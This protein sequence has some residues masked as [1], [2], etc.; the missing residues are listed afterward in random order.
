MNEVLGSIYLVINQINGKIYVG[1][2][3]KSIVRRWAEHVKLSMHVPKYP[4]HHAITKYGKENFQI[5]ELQKCF[6]QQE[7]DVTEMYWILL[8]RARYDKFGYNL[9]KGGQGVRGKGLWHHSQR[10]K[11][12]IS[13]GNKGKI[14]TDELRKR[15]STSVK[16]AMT[17]ELKQKI[18][19][20]TKIA[21]QN[22]DTQTKIE[23][24]NYAPRRKRIQQLNMHDIVIAEFT[25]ASEAAKVTRT[26]KG[27]LCACARGNFVQAG[28]F[29]WRYVDN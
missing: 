24:N 5:H 1:Q 20:R 6:S 11:F 10:A 21:I 4:L 16:R 7:L 12:A 19:Q 3:R 14:R 23:N 17:D 13:R 25:S 28:G 22:P 8:L 15:I 2:T 26:N 9:A 18:S 27:N 29:K